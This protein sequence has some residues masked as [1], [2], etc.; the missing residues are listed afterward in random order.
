MQIPA[1]VVQTYYNRVKSFADDAAKQYMRLIEQLEQANSLME[2]S[3]L[4]S[5]L[6]SFADS[7]LSIYGDAAAQTAADLY[8]QVA[9]LN[10][11]LVGNVPIADT[12]SREELMGEIEKLIDANTS[13]GVLDKEA[14]KKAMMAMMQV[15]VKRQAGQTIAEQAV[16]DN[17]GSSGKGNSKRK[18]KFARVP[19]G[20]ET[21]AF[22]IMLA[23]RGFVYATR[24]SAGQFNHYHRN[25]DCIV[26]PGF[27]DEVS[28][29][30]YD[31]KKWEDLYYDN[32]VEDDTDKGSTV[33]A[34]KTL[35]NIRRAVYPDYKDRRNRLRREEYARKKNLSERTT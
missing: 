27:G 6:V 13:N 1:Q 28:I 23:S 31:L 15:M 29:E 35:N 21:C 14:L 25:C 18:V 16:N 32:R 4:I 26:V 22:C 20:T 24:G 12:A 2:Q 8:V 11:I 5:Q 7:L 17:K 30:G 19:Q 3:E 9:E 10:G 34:N 33:N